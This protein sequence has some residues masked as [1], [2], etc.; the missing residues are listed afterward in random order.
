MRFLILG[1]SVGLTPPPPKKKF[2]RNLELGGPARQ[3]HCRGYKI[4]KV[5]VEVKSAFAKAMFIF[6]IK[7]GK[8]FEYIIT[9]LITKRE[10]LGRSDEAKRREKKGDGPRARAVI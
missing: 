1:R 4:N 2:R 3:H 8:M 9:F 7:A 6:Q 10:N 5:T